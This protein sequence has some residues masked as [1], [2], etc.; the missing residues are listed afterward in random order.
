MKYMGSKQSLLGNGLGDLLV[1]RSRSA[2]RIVD[3]FSGAGAVSWYAAE[4]TG[5]PVLAID[6]QQYS[7]VLAEAV[8]LRTEPLDG[9]VLEESWLELASR[10][11]YRSKIWR[12]AADAYQGSLT[13][14]EVHGAREMCR[15]PSSIGAIWNAYGG[16]YYSPAQAIAL[17]YLRSTMPEDGVLRPVC[18]GVLVMAASICAASPGHTAQP[19][20]PTRTAIR[21]IEAAWRRDPFDVIRKVLPDVTRRA[22]RVRGQAVVG[23]AVDIA[24]SM[25]ASD[26]V[27]VDP[28]YSAAQ[29]S[30]FYHVL[31]TVARGECGQVEGAGRYPPIEERP[32]SDF[33]KRSTSL[34]AVWK[35]LETLGE[36][37]AS[38]I[39]TFPQHGAS[40]GLEG[41]ELA[42]IAAEWFRVDVTSTDT[43]FSTLG[44]NGKQRASRRRGVELVLSLTP[45]TP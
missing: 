26:L 43:R 40:N 44:G 34:A 2:T 31:E 22:A 10:R 14:T 3:L 19:F 37:R 17:D 7:K 6:L 33:S 29:Y 25:T 45:R 23:D 9:S 11:L 18:L 30:R 32:Q 38:V 41:E 39:I 1:E 27:I 42:R 16:Y 35:L 4:H 12:E 28:P 36:A 15:R 24:T 20:R 21:H 13:A 8:I 5:V